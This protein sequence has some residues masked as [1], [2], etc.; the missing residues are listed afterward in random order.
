MVGG[1]SQFLKLV[2]GSDHNLR[3][4]AERITGNVHTGE[5]SITGM[6]G[7][8]SPPFSPTPGAYTKRQE[9]FTH[10]MV[11]IV[12]LSSSFILFLGRRIQF[13]DCTVPLS[14]Q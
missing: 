9:R 10:T 8:S 4:A 14:N 2:S 12:S 11:N 6:A 7:P 3:V 5:L 13:L 1:T